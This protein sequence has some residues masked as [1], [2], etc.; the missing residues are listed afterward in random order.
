MT[1]LRWFDVFIV[2]VYI[3]GL[4][5]I[6]LRFSRKQ[7]TTENYFMARR[8]IPSWAMGISFMARW[9]PA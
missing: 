7:T 5:A 6:G 1:H 3:F 8:S 4:T 2:G 9:S